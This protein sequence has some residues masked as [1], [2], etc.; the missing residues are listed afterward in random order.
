[1]IPKT[2]SDTKLKHILATSGEGFWPLVEYF[3]PDI[4]SGSST[5]DKICSLTDDIE[6]DLF[7]DTVSN[8]AEET[9][10]TDKEQ[11]RMWYQALVK[12]SLFLAHFKPQSRNIQ[13]K[14][15]H[16]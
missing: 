12:C 16:Q 4:S 6:V 13:I 2:L 15:R 8:I 1:M 5:A 14:R 7:G 9:Q 10:L 3:A 11:M